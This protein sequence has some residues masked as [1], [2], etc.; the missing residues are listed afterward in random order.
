[1]PLVIIALALQVAAAPV[2][3]L[4][5][6]EQRYLAARD[7]ANSRFA[8]SD[9]ADDE[10]SRVL[11]ELTA[12]LRAIVGPVR[13][14]GIDGPGKAA[15]DAFSGI[16]S[17]EMAD[18]LCFTWRGSGLFVTTRALF[19]RTAAATWP[20]RDPTEA[21]FSVTVFGDA[22]YSKFAEIS[23]RHGSSVELARASVGLVAQDIGAWPPNTLVV[24]V[25]RGDRVYMVGTDLT[26]R[27]EQV[28][29]CAAKCGSC[30]DQA[31]F[32]AYRRCVGSVLPTRPSFAGVV[33][34]A[35]AIVDALQ[36]DEPPRLQGE[37]K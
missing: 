2:P 22:A 1:M 18:G 7:A 10:Q 21:L 34:R 11:A 4:S 26:P 36:A 19:A 23:V 20:A 28:P 5:A 8:N 6:A 14:S 12:Q 30:G 15:Y 29:S 32:D 17:T 37:Q 35:Q 9:E 33:R 16:G 31:A 13:L 27:L 24:Q 25:V 3:K